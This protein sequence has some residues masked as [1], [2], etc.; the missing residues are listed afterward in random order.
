[1]PSIIFFKYSW[2]Q[3]NA[4]FCLDHNS[5]RYLWMP[6][7]ASN[8]VLPQ[9][10]RFTNRL[11][12]ALLL[13][14]PILFFFFNWGSSYLVIWACLAVSGLFLLQVCPLQIRICI[15][16]VTLPFTLNS[17]IFAENWGNTFHFRSHISS[18]MPS[19][20]HNNNSCYFI[21]CVEQRT[22]CCLI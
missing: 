10:D 21:I 2:D 6:H 20:L 19:F 8:S 16:S 9:L 1:M 17:W 18:P 11:L 13:N 14:R 15:H 3:S 7:F 5:L 4:L 22:F 12:P